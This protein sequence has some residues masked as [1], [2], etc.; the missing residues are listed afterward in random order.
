MNGKSDV[1]DQR[2]ENLTKLN[3]ENENISDINDSEYARGE[4]PNSLKNLKPFPKGV[5]GNPLGRPHKY[6]KLAESLSKLGSNKVF[7]EK[8]N[9]SEYETIETDKTWKENVLETVW[10]K[11]RM[12][13]IKFV[14]LL[15]YL[16][17]LD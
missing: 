14:Q 13:D 12:G 9:G 3:V 1:N 17:C 15:A 5:S 16:G 2:I 4:H 8:W 10:A 7:E 6:T 11:A